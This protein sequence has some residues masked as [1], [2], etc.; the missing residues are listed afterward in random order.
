[1]IMFFLISAV[2][3]PALAWL[4]L[5]FNIVDQYAEIDEELVMTETKAEAQHTVLMRTVKSPFFY[6]YSI[7][8][9][10]MVSSVI[11]AYNAFDLGNWYFSL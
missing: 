9:I 6:I 11:I 1:M 8:T 5:Y 4:L 7:F 10:T 3:M 2:I